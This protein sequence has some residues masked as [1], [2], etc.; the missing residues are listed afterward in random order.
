MAA[1]RKS[2]LEKTLCKWDIHV[3]LVTKGLI[4]LKNHRSFTMSSSP[5]NTISFQNVYDPLHFL[6]L[7]APAALSNATYIRFFPSIFH[8]KKSRSGREDDTML[9]GLMMMDNELEGIWREVGL[10]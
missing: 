5:I 9:T 6:S 10:A 1:W 7:K 4:I 8:I 2:G 3:P